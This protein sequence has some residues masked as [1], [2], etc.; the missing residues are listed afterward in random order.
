M[1]VA[2]LILYLVKDLFNIIK[3]GGIS[4]ARSV[5]IIIYWQ[6]LIWLFDFE[7]AFAPFA[8]LPL[9]RGTVSFKVSVSSKVVRPILLRTANLLLVLILKGVCSLCGMVCKLENPVFD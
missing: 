1:T 4:V 7:E 5:N 8:H 6:L 3:Q 9:D 2:N